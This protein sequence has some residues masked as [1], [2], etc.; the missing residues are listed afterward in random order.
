MGRTGQLREVAKGQFSRIKTGSHQK[1]IYRQNTV[2]RFI[3]TL[4]ACSNVPPSWFGLNREHIAKVV[5]YWRKKRLTDDTIRMYLA[6]IRYFLQAINHQLDG[7]DNKS[8]GLNRTVSV[9]RKAFHN[10]C[11]QKISD[12]IVE[13]LI[14]LQTEFGLTLSESFRF[15]P[16]IHARTEYLLLS[17]DITNNSKDRVIDIYSDSQKQLIT[18]AQ[19]VIEMNLNPIKQYG[20]DSLRGR[21]AVEVKRI[22]LTPSVN[23]RYVFAQNRFIELCKDMD[24]VNARKH[25]LLEM[26]ISERALRRYLNE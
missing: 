11:L 20:Y 5:T 21:Y 22:G 6:E 19:S 7:I 8:L 10:D 16:D 18:L 4:Y 3:D 9:K 26:G 1:R 12:P 2:F 25:L 13:V 14:R 15:T 17:R 24:K 23:Y